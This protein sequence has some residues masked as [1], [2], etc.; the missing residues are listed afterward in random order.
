LGI[1]G[2]LM[3]RKRKKKARRISVGTWIGIIGVLVGII[4]LFL[5]LN[6]RAERE[7]VY[8]INPVRTAVVTAGQASELAVFYEGEPLGSVDVTAAQVAIW[9]EGK[10]SIREEN[11]LED[12]VI[13]ADPPVPILEASIGQYSREVTKFT[14]VGTPESLA[15][16]RVPVSWYILENKDGA[17][18][19]LIYVGTEEVDFYVEGVIE[20]LRGIKDVELRVATQTPQERISKQQEIRWV[21]LGLACII[22]VAMMFNIYLVFR[23]G[24]WRRRDFIETAIYL[25]FT[26]FCILGYFSYSVGLWPPFGF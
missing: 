13:C 5:Y 12:V 2:V 18:V 26:V 10:Q 21:I 11:I 17:S 4:S 3:E 16:G 8:A 19:Q 24:T 1:E 22:G 23:S 6:S 7:L 20:G 9:N 14:L 25:G 15:S